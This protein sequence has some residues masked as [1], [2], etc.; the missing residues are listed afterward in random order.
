[1]KYSKKLPN[2]PTKAHLKFESHRISF[3]GGS[4]PIKRFSVTREGSYPI[5]A[6][7]SLSIGGTMLG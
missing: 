7:I 6:C 5:Y 1:M 4:P 2:H 3:D